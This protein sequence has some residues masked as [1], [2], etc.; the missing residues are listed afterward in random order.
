MRFSMTEKCANGMWY[1]LLIKRGGTFVIRMVS[2]DIMPSELPWDHQNNRYKI[3]RMIT[4][5]S[6]VNPWQQQTH[7]VLFIRTF[8]KPQQMYNFIG[9]IFHWLVYFPILIHLYFKPSFL[10]FSAIIPLVPQLKGENHFIKS[11]RIQNYRI[12]TLHYQ[13]GLYMQ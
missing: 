11:W 6:C 12:H 4:G 13:T 3:C 9:K 2:L 7:V 5:C 1:R 10:L 8:L